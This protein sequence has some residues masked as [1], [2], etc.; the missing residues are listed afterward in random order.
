MCSFQNIFYFL[1]SLIR[2][3]DWKTG[4]QWRTVS[5]TK[6]S[7]NVRYA[8]GAILDPLFWIL[9]FLP[10]IW[11]RRH[12]NPLR[13]FLAFQ[14]LHWLQY[15]CINYPSHIECGRHF[16]SA[17]LNFLILTSNLDSATSKIPKKYFNFKIL[18]LIPI[19]MWK[20]PLKCEGYFPPLNLNLRRY[21]KKFMSIIFPNSTNLQS[22]IPIGKW[23]FRSFT[24]KPHKMFW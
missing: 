11:I 17:I 19:Q 1:Q 5:C 3:I 2:Y 22:F 10:Q 6:I 23:Y 12:Q 13:S 4:N 14:S 16:L 9:Y 20:P 7:C 8:G 21:K 18:H 15:K 24:C